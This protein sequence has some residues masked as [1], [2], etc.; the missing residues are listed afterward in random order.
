M[1]ALAACVVLAA[2][3]TVNRRPAIIKLPERCVVLVLGAMVKLTDPAPEPVAP[4]V[5]VIQAA[6]LAA[7]QLQPVVVVTSDDPVPPADVT[8]WLVGEIES[9][10]ADAFCVTVYAWL[11]IVMVP[12]RDCVVGLA[13]TLN[14]TRAL[15]VPP[16]PPD[17]VNQL[18]LLTAVQAHPSAAVTFVN[19]DPRPDPTVVLVGEIA[20]AQA[21]PAW[22][23]VRL[24]PPIVSVPLRCVVLALAAALK[25][26]DPPPLPLA[27]L[28]TVSHD[29][30]LLTP[31]HAQPV[32]AVTAVDPVPPAAATDWLAG[33][34]A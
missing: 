18:A 13:V 26:T 4:L 19:P 20:T 32:G 10:H 6:L 9:E 31:V 29:V 23:T 7:V 17:T 16:P 30:L 22:L 33:L 8:V 34:I 12:V 25:P 28:V 27:P 21:T 14:V 3:V 15:P 2:C 24:C 11:P 1:H 5:M